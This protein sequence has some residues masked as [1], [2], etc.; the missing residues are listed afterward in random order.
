VSAPPRKS[1]KLRSFAFDAVT[2]DAEGRVIARHRGRAHRFIQR[3]G[4]DVSLHLVQIPGGTFVMGAPETEPNSR[5]CE[6]PQHR[7]T[8]PPF[9]LGTYPVTLDQW[10]AV[11]GARPADM[12]SAERAFRQSGRQPVVRV[13]CGEAEEFCARLSRKTRRAH[14]RRTRRAQPADRVSRG[15]DGL[16]GRYTPRENT[17]HSRMRKS[18][19]I[20]QLSM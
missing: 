16:G 3:L 4:K 2:L 17:V 14:G 18:S 20:D 10:R 1:R 5:P 12:K 15:D 9:Y 6:Q 7:V 8:V 13:S 11:M 19:H